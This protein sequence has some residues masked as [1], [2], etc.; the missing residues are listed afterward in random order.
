M[1]ESSV[2]A[3]P[4]GI[5]QILQS[6]SILPQPVAPHFNSIRLTKVGSGRRDDEQS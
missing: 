6:V 1:W 3:V 5:S 4:I 2:Y